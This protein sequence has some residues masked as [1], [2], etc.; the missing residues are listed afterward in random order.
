MVLV[1]VAPVLCRGRCAGETRREIYYF[2]REEDGE[3]RGGDAQIC[4]FANLV[5]L[6]LTEPVW[7]AA[8]AL[9]SAT[10]RRR[11]GCVE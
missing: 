6:T 4:E 7:L 8:A 10:T 1:V 2:G 5:M 11:Y 3:G 9:K